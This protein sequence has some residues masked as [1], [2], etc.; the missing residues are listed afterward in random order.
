MPSQNNIQQLVC[1]AARKVFLQKPHFTVITLRK[2]LGTFWEYLCNQNIDHLWERYKP[3][4]KNILEYI[5][6]DDIILLVEEEITAYL[7]R[8]LPAASSDTLVLFL[9]STTWSLCI[10]DVSRIRW[11]KPY[12]DL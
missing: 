12:S 5:D 10:E 3:S 11:P 2:G 4:N 9:H 8:Y 1:D 6:F 7:K